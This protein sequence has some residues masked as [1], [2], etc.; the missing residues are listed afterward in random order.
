MQAERWDPIRHGDLI[1]SWSRAR[2]GDGAP[3]QRD[4]LPPTGVVVGG[5]VAA[6]L[7]KTDAS[8]AYIDNI[9]SDPTSDAEARSLAL[10]AAIEALTAE[11]VWS[12]FGLV[13]CVTGVPTLARTLRAHGWTSLAGEASYLARRVGC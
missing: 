4:V 1:A 6:F 8:V 10:D 9:I 3:F 11:A 5:I 7:M 2:F 13:V 12:G